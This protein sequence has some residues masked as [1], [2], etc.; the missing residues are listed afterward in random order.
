MGGGEGVLQVRIE[1]N[2][3][4]AMSMGVLFLYCR[5]GVGSSYLT[6]PLKRTKCVKCTQVSANQ[7][8]SRTQKNDWEHS[9]VYT[10]ARRP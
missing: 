4:C 10:H 8:F 6:L 5:E 1:G 7:P 9:H 3:P 2:G